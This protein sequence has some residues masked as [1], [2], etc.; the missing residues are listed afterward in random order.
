[1]MDT[2]LPNRQMD[3]EGCPNT[4]SG[5]HRGKSSDLSLVHKLIELN[6]VEFDISLRFEKP[7][8]KVFS[9]D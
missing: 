9:T 4:T 6:Q 8:N 1:M 5:L 2:F 3:I 7:L